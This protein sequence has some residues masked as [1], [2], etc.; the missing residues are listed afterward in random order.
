MLLGRSSSAALPNPKSPEF[1]GL[2][3]ELML[4]ASVIV[5]V[6]TSRG[7]EVTQQRW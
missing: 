4:E 1:S 5:A 6:K 3:A 7:V 2:S